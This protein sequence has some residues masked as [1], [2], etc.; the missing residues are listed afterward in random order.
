M[1]RLAWKCQVLSDCMHTGALLLDVWCDVFDAAW[2]DS[3][4]D[5]VLS[6][7]STEMLLGFGWT[8]CQKIV[9]LIFID[10]LPYF[11]RLSY[12][13]NDS[14]IKHACAKFLEH[15]VVPY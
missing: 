4:L 15:A 13:G 12:I 6:F 2:C 11:L 9:L 5:V 8:P 7:L 1:D 14:R 10:R 3:F